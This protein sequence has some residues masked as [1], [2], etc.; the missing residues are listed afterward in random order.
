MPLGDL[1][2]L[3]PGSLRFLRLSPSGHKP[4][5]TNLDTSFFFS[6]ISN[7]QMGPTPVEEP[8]PCSSGQSTPVT[9]D[10][11]SPLGSR[12]SEQTLKKKRMWFS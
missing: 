4:V 2:A 3:E 10:I 12:G 5:L 6:T 7:A 8:Q 11:L 9:P 1:E